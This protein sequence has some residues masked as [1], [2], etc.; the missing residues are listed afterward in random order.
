MSYTCIIYI[1]YLFTSSIDTSDDATLRLRSHAHSPVRAK[2]R[3]VLPGPQLSARLTK[4]CGSDT[5]SPQGGSWP[6]LRRGSEKVIA[7]NPTCEI[8]LKTANERKNTG[9]RR[10]EDVKRSVKK[11]TAQELKLGRRDR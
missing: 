9:D 5:Y 8:Q 6:L 2:K 3:P 1:I 4:P 7:D 11:D 10:K